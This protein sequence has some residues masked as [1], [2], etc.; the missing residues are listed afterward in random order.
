MSNNRKDNK[1]TSHKPAWFEVRND[2]P[3]IH[4]NTGLPLKKG[5][6]HLLDPA[7]VGG[8]E[9]NELF[10]PVSGP[11]KKKEDPPASTKTAGYEEVKDA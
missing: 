11:H 4:G 8:V 3:G 10:K 7:Q 2:V 6:R 9:G 5:E 1:E